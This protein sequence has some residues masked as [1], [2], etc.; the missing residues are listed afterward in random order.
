MTIPRGIIKYEQMKNFL[1]NSLDTKSLVRENCFGH[2]LSKSLKLDD[3]DDPSQVLEWHINFWMAL[4]NHMLF[5]TK[6]NFVLQQD[7]TGQKLWS[8][9]H[10]KKTMYIGQDHSVLIS[11]LHLGDSINHYFLYRL[12]NSGSSHGLSNFINIILLSCILFVL[13]C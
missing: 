10:L 4:I 2:S 11:K 3:Q 8:Y 9:G 6:K 12:K 13:F 5:Y 1:V 7:W